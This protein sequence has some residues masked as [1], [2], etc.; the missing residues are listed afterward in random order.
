MAYRDYADWNQTGLDQLF[1]Y[2]ANIDHGVG[3]IFTG[4]LLFSVFMITLLGSYFSSKRFGDGDFAA[5]FATAGFLT[6]IIALVMTLIPGLINMATVIITLIVA[7]IGV[8]F[9]YFSSRRWYKQAN[10]H[11]YHT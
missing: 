4:L 1:V 3:I 6:F 7:I 9:L 5:S 10:I 11:L 8:L 2:A